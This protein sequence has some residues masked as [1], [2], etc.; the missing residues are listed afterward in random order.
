MTPEIMMDNIDMYRSR[1]REENIQCV[2]MDVTKKY[3][4]LT[5][6]EMLE[7]AHY[8]AD[9]IK[10]NL[11]RRK[12]WERCIRE[13]TIIQCFLG[14]IGWYSADDLMRHTAGEQPPHYARRTA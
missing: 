7:H 9:K 3:S 2:R 10:Q 8:L 14:F 6:R 12:S 5:R 1:L 4:S 13:F 11:E